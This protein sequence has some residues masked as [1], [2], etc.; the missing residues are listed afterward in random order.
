M[1][2]Q[3]HKFRPP[4]EK[5]TAAAVK[6]PLP[7]ASDRLG[8]EQLL[9]PRLAHTLAVLLVG[10]VGLLVV[11]THILSYISKT[12]IIEQEFKRATAE[13]KGEPDD[14][15]FKVEAIFNDALWVDQISIIGG[16]ILL[17]L[18]MRMTSRSLPYAWLALACFT[19]LVL[20]QG[21]RQSDEEFWGNLVL[22]LPALAV[23]G[24]AVF[25]ARRANSDDTKQSGGTKQ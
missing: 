20:V 6:L 11:L 7:G 18:A 12:E 19:T 8:V 5:E 4:E 9:T 24:G 3:K 16:L 23:L 15:R 1:A 21:S 17:I 10:T 2:K 22:Q 13:E 14:I 25:F